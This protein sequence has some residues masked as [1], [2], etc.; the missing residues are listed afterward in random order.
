MSIRRVSTVVII[1]IVAVLLAV[2]ALTGTRH[3]KTA[4]RREPTS[5][6]VTTGILP[7]IQDRAPTIDLD[8]N[9]LDI[10]AD[11]AGQ[12]LPQNPANRHD[13]RNPGYLTDPPAGLDWQRGWGGAAFPVSTSDGPEKISN[14]I[15]SGFAR[16]PQ[17]AAMAACD[18]IAR[19]LAAPDSVWQN[20][21]RQRYLGGGQALVDRIGRSRTENPGAARY[22]IVPDGI[23]VLPGYQP[24]FAVVQIAVR[25]QDGWAYGTWPMT[26][27][28]GDWRV[29]VPDDLDTLWQP[30]IP[31][32]D[33]T[34]FGQWKTTA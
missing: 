27:N 1:S 6:P 31:V 9:R 16:T 24:D 23:R 34:D 29:R 12:A 15:A 13:P 25:A 30:A 19:A 17:G 22:A 10:P 33:L 26:W 18:A 20:V 7:S 2:I 14:G 28:A 8:G 11:S 32:A 21:I 3:E 4:A 5:S